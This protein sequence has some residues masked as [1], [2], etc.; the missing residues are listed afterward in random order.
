M[1]S[2]GNVR[3]R[4]V[5]SDGR[6][7]AQSMLATQQ[8][9]MITSGELQELCLVSLTDY[10]VN[11]VQ[12]KRWVLRVVKKAREGASFTIVIV[13]LWSSSADA[14]KVAAVGNIMRVNR[15]PTMPSSCNKDNNRAGR[16]AARACRVGSIGHAA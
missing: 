3:W 14:E 16:F 6:H 13:H 4:L 7:Y 11:I 2:T 12:N 15:S 1:T 9:E 5:L 8:N 10:I